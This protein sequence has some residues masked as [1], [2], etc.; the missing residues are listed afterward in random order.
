MAESKR[1]HFSGSGKVQILKRHLVDRVPDSDLCDEYKLY[2][3]QVYD[4]L[5]EFFENA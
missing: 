2:P 4:C 1:R 3:T 5:K